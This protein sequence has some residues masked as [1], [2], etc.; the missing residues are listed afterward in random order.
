MKIIEKDQIIFIF[1]IFFNRMNGCSKYMYIFTFI[2]F[3]FMKQKV[4]FDKI[5]QVISLSNNYVRH[6]K[7]LR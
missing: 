6:K 1:S 3:I 7:N 4:G 2:N 5:T